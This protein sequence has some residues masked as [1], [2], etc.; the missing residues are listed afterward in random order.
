[1]DSQ[2]QK[3]C[4]T[5][6]LLPEVPFVSFLAGLTA[7]ALLQVSLE[8]MVQRVNPEFFDHL[9]TDVRRRY[10]VY[11][12]TWLGTMFKVVSITACT[13]SLFTV[14]AE[15]DIA[16][17]VRPLSTAEQWCWGCRAIIYIPE[18]PHIASIPELVIHHILSIG[19]M[20]SILAFNIPRRQM[21]VAWA[22]LWSEFV[23][24]AR[25][26]LKMHGKLSQRLSWW[27]GTANVLL[28][29]A[30]RV[31]GCFV[32]IVWTLQSGTR[33]M[34]LAI[35]I[36]CWTIY[37]VYMLQV[38]FWEAKRL[39]LVSVDLKQPATIIIAERFNISFYGIIMGL[40]LVCT[41]L[42]ALSIYEARVKPLGSV[43]ELHSIAWATLQA[44]LVGLLG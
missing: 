3:T 35:D 12:S 4:S 38:S 34:P 32:A 19:A 2:A 18:L 36:G 40:A 21:Y 1:M 11:F 27:L 31:T 33:G 22:G 15:T 26:L 6:A 17:L 13:A 44:V 7:W 43:D 29:V 37:L 20:I 24:N 14:P 9:K 8:F 10:N 5:A 23:S 39:K 30:F 25:R 42:S 16:G 28:I 41:E